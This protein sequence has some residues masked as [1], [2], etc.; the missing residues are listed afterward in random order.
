M[1]ELITGYV[2]SIPA[3]TCKKCG[4]RPV[5]QV[6]MDGE[7]HTEM[8]RVECP[9]GNHTAKKFTKQKALKF[10]NNAESLRK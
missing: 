2:Y 4:N 10:W 8:Y 3:V 1:G 6:V 7:S 9:C 5:I